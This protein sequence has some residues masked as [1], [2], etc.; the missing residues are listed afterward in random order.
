MIAALSLT[1]INPGFSTGNKVHKYYIGVWILSGL[2][3]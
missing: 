1:N 3:M 2:R